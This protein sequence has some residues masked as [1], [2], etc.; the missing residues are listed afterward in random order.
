MFIGDISQLEII[1]SGLQYPYPFNLS[2]GSTNVSTG[3]DRINQ[4]IS[5]I[6]S[7]PIGTRLFNPAFGSNIQSFL[8]EDTSDYGPLIVA[9]QDALTKWEKRISV[10]SI[11]VTQDSQDPHQL[12]ISI[13]YT[14]VGT[15]VQGNYVYPL[16]TSVFLYGQ[17][18][19]S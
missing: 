9:I 13:T 3:E 8:F 17:N 16:N 2:T 14:I 18:T 19:A 10:N 6:L 12:N 11:N 1:G 15:N 4:S 5:I 7:T